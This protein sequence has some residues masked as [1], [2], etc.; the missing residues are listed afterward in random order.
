M[1]IGKGKKMDPDEFEKEIENNS[2][3]SAE[4]LESNLGKI[5]ECFQYSDL[6]GVSR[7]IAVR[8]NWVANY[9]FR[10][11]TFDGE[12]NQ[13]V[14]DALFSLLKSR[15]SAIYA[16]LEREHCQCAGEKNGVG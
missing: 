5:L 9:V 14:Y 16:F 8:F 13:Y 12:P 4:D 7:N 11:N 3:F 2:I 15:N 10:T 6:K 1:Y